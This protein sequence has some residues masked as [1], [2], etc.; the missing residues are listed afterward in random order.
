MTDLLHLQNSGGTETNDF[1]P[2][3]LQREHDLFGAADAN[4]QI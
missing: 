1:H 4:M 3:R 2:S